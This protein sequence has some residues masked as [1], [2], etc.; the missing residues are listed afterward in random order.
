M[1]H[2][3]F[4]TIKSSHQPSTTIYFIM[5]NKETRI[6]HAHAQ[7][8][9]ALHVHCTH[10]HARC[11]HRHA[12]PRS[13]YHARKAGELDHP[14]LFTASMVGFVCFRRMNSDSTPMRKERFGS[15]LAFLEV[16]FWLVEEKEW[17]E[18]EEEG[19]HSTT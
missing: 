7:D 8:P 12:L 6:C 18:E 11:T 9:C 13:F 17:R 3:L 15:L 4:F 5:I 16:S 19:T 10:C 2:R 14:W 1:D